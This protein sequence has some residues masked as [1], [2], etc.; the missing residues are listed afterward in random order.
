MINVELDLIDVFEIFLSTMVDEKTHEVIMSR[1][2][3][4][5]KKKYL[6]L[7][8]ENNS[9]KIDNFIENKI[10]IVDVRID[11]IY[12]DTHKLKVK[13]AYEIK[14]NGMPFLEYN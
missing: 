6:N 11:L 12:V 2:A 5:D 7:L 8:I 13:T 3:P 4:N 9:Q 10:G 1:L 14:I